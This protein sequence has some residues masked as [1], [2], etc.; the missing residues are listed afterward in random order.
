MTMTMTMLIQYDGPAC[1][2]TEE[3]LHFIDYAYM[4]YI[5][6]DHMLRLT[7]PRLE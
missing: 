1:L 2:K 7:Q 4:L 3:N 6:H 5:V